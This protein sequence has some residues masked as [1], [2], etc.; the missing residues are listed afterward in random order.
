M[1]QRDLADGFGSVFLPHALAA[2]N[3]HAA[4]DWRWQ[5]VFPAQKYVGRSRH[6]RAA[7]T[8]YS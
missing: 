8:S 2:K 5:W 1:H 7:A 4:T 6:W 3:P